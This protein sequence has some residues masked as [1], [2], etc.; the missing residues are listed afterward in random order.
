MKFKVEIEMGNDAM[1]RKADVIRALENI[2]NRMRGLSSKQIEG[3]PVH[4]DNG[5]RV[6]MF[7]FFDED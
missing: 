2:C 6:G 4:D 5:N 7:G 1:Q 3:L